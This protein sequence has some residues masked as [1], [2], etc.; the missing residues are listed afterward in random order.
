MSRRIWAI[1]VFV[2]TTAL[3]LAGPVL[4]VLAGEPVGVNELILPAVYAFAVVGLLIALHRPGNTVAW[5]CL[6]VALAFGLE[7]ALWGVFFYGLAHPG[8]V[9]RPEVW[10]VAGASFTMPASS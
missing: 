4:V 2:V 9:A 1:V 10:A 6:G 7:N 3:F 8:T 5:I